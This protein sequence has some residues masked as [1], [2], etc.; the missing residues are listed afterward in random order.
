M[1]I[2][3]LQALMQKANGKEGNPHFDPD[4]PV[5][6]VLVASVLAQAIKHGDM[7][8][9]T[10]MANFIIGKPKPVEINEDASDPANPANM[11]KAIPSAYL[12]DALRKKASEAA[13]SGD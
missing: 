8:R 12:I 4:T 3:E 2:G 1:S 10:Y 13:E 5:V 6:D 7:A 9:F 11:L